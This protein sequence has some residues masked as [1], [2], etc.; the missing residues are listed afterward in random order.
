MMKRL[1]TAN[2]MPLFALCVSAGLLIG[3]WIF[4][5][6]FGYVPC[7]MCYWQRHAHKLV[8]GLAILGLIISHVGKPD[9]RYINALLILALVFSAALG[10]WHMGVEYKWWEGPKTCLGGDID[11]DTISSGTDL[12]NSLS[13]PVKPPACSE[14]AWH[15]LGLSMAAWNMVI[16]GAA[17]IFTVRFGLRKPVA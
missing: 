15:F 6:G 4:Q 8:I 5:Y 7:Q 17:A 3:A 12:L 10:L 9:I 2:A 13:D 11:L 14:A 1:L 16:S